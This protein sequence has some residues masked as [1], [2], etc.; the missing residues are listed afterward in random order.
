MLDDVA[1]AIRSLGGDYRTFEQLGRQPYTTP[2]QGTGTSAQPDD[3]VLVA[4][5]SP[6]NTNSPLLVGNVVE[7]SSFISRQIYAYPPT[8][9]GVL[10]T[11]LAGYLK[12]DHQGY[13]GTVQR[14]LVSGIFRPFDWHVG[15]GGRAAE[16]FL[17][18]FPVEWIPLH[19]SPPRIST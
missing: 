7:A 8:T 2:S 11:N 13:Y 12:L 14:Y 15:V 18:F 10:E 17:A 4:Q 1:A 3:Y 9:N 6:N 5:H 19:S 16:R